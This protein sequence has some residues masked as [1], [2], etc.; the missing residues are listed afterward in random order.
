LSL[1]ATEGEFPRLSANAEWKNPRE[2]NESKAIGLEMMRI[3]HNN[4]L[5][6]E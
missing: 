2:S 1:T 6:N 5:L 3:G 4:S